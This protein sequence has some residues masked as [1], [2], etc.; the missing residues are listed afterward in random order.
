MANNENK[1]E[2]AKLDVREY[3]PEEISFKVENG[4]VKV[5]GRH[6][7]EGPFGFELKEF[8]RTFT[9]PEGVE[10]SN[11]KTRISNHGQLHIEAMKALPEPDGAKKESKDD[12][13]SMA[14]D[15]KG[16]PPEAIKVQV[17]G[18]ELLVS[19]NH[20]VEH[21][22]H[23][24]AMHFNRQFILPREVDMDSLT[25]RLD[26]EGKLHFEA[27]KRNAP[28]LPPVRELKVLRDK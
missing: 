11:V 21:E 18:N 25:T 10:A 24:H 12:K 9:L 7:N 17:L 6:V 2:I 13:F 5:Q 14:M 26:K 1:L 8:R 23:H 15:V 22:G 16:F 3:R 4:V 28:A 27:K 19:A 20:E